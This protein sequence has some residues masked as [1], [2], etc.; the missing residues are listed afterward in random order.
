MDMFDALRKR[1]DYERKMR[2]E[3]PIS[4]RISAF[5]RCDAAYMLAI[6]SWMVWMGFI[7]I[8]SMIAT[9]RPDDP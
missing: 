8:W 3:N 7:V 6:A 9:S 1:E 4:M 2:K 5:V